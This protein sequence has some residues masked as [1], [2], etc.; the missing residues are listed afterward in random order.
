[1]VFWCAIFVSKGNV[2][3][4]GNTDDTVD[5][6]LMSVIPRHHFATRQVCLKIAKLLITAGS[7]VTIPNSEDETPV[8]VAYQQNLFDILTFIFPSW[9]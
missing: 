5:I 4:G 6:S 9:G 8:D 1:M 7:N 3:N 2:T